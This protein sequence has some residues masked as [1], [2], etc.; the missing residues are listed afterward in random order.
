MDDNAIIE[1][2]FARSEQAI[3]YGVPISLFWLVMGRFAPHAVRPGPAG[4]VIVLTMWAI[5]TS[6]MRNAY[7][8]LLAQR[9]CGGM[10][11][12]ILQPLD[13]S[14]QF[15]KERALTIGCFLLPTALGMGLLWGRKHTM[16]NWS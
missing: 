1:L 8:F 12:Q 4:A 9:V 6:L 14:S 15:D 11:E 16:S 7:L 10:L 3:A 5:L 13:Y 2:F